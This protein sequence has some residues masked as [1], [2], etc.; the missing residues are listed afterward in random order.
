[1]NQQKVE[2][3]LKE[4]FRMYGTEI[5]RERRRFR[6]ALFDLLS[7]SQYQRSDSVW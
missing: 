5:V 2:Q 6:S 3:V 1:M 4:I 7:E